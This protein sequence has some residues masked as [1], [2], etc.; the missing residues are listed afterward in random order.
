MY[1]TNVF[2]FTSDQKNLLAIHI[3]TANENKCETLR[4]LVSQVSLASNIH[5]LTSAIVIIGLDD[6][7]VV[8]I[9][10]NYSH[11]ISNDNHNPIIVAKF[12]NTIIDLV[13]RY[14]FVS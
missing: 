7:R 10:A 11:Q 6:F 13:V 3:D 4:F 9:Y 2:T 5:F 12:I 14:Q 1:I 8:N